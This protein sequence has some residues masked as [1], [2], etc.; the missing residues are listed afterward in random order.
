MS[1]GFPV[2]VMV[3]TPAEVVLAQKR[4]GAF[5]PLHLQTFFDARRENAYIEWDE[6]WRGGTLKATWKGSWTLEELQS[7]IT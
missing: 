5:Y 1:P 6:G 2:Q 4:F 3:L 7:W